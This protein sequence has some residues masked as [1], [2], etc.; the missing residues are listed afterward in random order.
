M[1]YVLSMTSFL[2]SY[3]IILLYIIDFSHVFLF[4][5]QRNCRQIRLNFLGR[6]QT[7]VWFSKKKFTKKLRICYF[8]LKLLNPSNQILKLL[9]L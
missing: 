9:V 5:K 2:F 8:L 1:K 4:V 7:T 6:T 3:H